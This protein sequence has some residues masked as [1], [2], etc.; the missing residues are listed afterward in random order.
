MTHSLSYFD[1]SQGH[2]LAYIYTPAR[3]S[4]ENLPAV[5]FL[6]G[7][8]SDMEG[9]KALYLQE[10]CKKREQAF[11]RF[12]YS[13]HGRSEGEFVDGT[14]GSWA[15]DAKDII[16]NI[17]AGQ[18]LILVGSSMG[19][20]ISLRLL[21]DRPDNIRAVVGIAAAPDFTKDI[22]AQMRDEDRVMMQ[23]LGR[24]EVANDYSDQPYIFTKD[25]IEDGRQQ[26]VLTQAHSIN[27]PLIL[28]QGK[29]DADVPWKKAISIQS[30]FGHDNTEIVFIEDGDHR[31]SRDQDLALIDAQV[32]KILAEL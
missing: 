3:K 11:L 7:F 25:L 32:E 17:L 5:V 14:I 12:D 29:Q 4:G 2:K 18:D 1:A 16:N 19:G 27:V 28:L 6:G 10:Q 30:C 22:E 23:E 24:L 9:T 13:G 20:W 15:Q 21:I 26:F 8:K 31:L